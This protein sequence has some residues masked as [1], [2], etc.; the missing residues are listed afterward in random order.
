LNEITEDI[1]IIE[2]FESLYYLLK[3]KE[4]PGMSIG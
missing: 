3:L 4:K 2:Q 1:L